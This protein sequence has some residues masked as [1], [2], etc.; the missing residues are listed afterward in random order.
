MNLFRIDFDGGEVFLV[1]G[2]DKDDALV[3][4]RDE[5]GFAPEDLDGV[6]VTEFGDLDEVELVDFEEDGRPKFKIAAELLVRRYGRGIAASTE[7]P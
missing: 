1:V 5:C 3:V 2:E 6:E 7:H 4:M